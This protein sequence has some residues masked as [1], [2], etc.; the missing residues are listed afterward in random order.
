MHFLAVLSMKNR[1]LIALITIVAAVFGGLALTNLKQELIPSI[2]FPQVAIVSS[3]PGASPEV[4]NNDVSTP[5]ET[6]IQG[7]P[8]LE[9]TSAVSSTN[10]SLI[11]VQFTYGTNLATAEQKLDQAIN[12][13]KSTLPDGVDPQVVSGSIDDLPVIQLAVTGG[14]DQKALGEQITKLA[15]PDIKDV[16]G[17]N[18]AQL[19]GEVGQR[20]TIVPDAAKLAAAGF[21]SQSIKDALQQNGV[22]I[23]GG[24]ITEDDKTLS[25]QSG[26]Q[27][28][29]VDDIASLPL[30]RSASASAG[31]GAGAGASAGAGAGASAGAGPSAAAG[32]AA[33]GA[34]ATPSATATATPTIGEVATV[35]ETDDP[36]TSLSRVDGKP[37]LT[38][39]VTKLPS[40]NTVDVS[41][42]VNALIDDLQTKLGDGV[43]IT[44]VFDQAPF[45]TQ[46]INSLTEEGLLGLL[47][48]V[49]VILVFLLSIRSTLVTAISIPT[50]VLITFI[51]MQATGYTLNI[52]TLGAL[53][54]AIGRVV[55]DSIVVIENIK[56]ELVAGVDRASTIVKA[57][58]EVAGA[59]TASTIVTVAVF[60]PLAF[61]GDVTG[62]LFRPF[63]TTVTIALLSSLLV[64]LTIV[65]VLAYWFLRPPKPRKHEGGAVE[66]ASSHL[67]IDEAIA[68][69]DDELKHPSWLQRGYLPIIHWTLKHSVSTIMIAVLVLV[70]TVFLFPLM[71]TNFLGSSGQNTL[72]ISQTLPPGTSLEAQNSASKPVE[73][74]LLDTKGIDI[75]QL[76]IGSSGSALRDAFTGGGG[77]ITY[78]VTTD[79]DVDQDKLKNTVENELA[80]ITDQGQITVSS[81]QGFG[82]SNDI[83]VNIT[84]T[85]NADLQKATDAVAAQIEK[86]GSIKQTTDNLSASLPYVAVKVNRADAAKA[87]LSEVA[88]G[89][90]VSQAVQ[91]STVGNIAIDNTTLKIYL[92]S[93]N[94]PTTVA[95]LS[96]LEIPTLAGPAR[97]DTLATVAETN[98]PSTVTTERGLRTATV[99]ATPGTDNLG[100]AN[101]DVTKALDSVDLPA[102]ATAKIGGVS[103]SQSD[104]FSQLGLALLA[105][106][107]I[108][109]IVMVATFRSLRQPLL[110]LVSVPFAATG[111]I[112]LQVI[113]GIPLGVASLIGLL[114]LIGIVVTNAIVLIDL[115]N[116]YRRRG[117]SVEDA[118]AHGSSRRL[119]PILMTALATIAALTPMAIGLTGHGGFISQPLAIVV[120]GGL[121]SST[122]LTL[123]VLPTLYNFVEGWKER[124]ASRRTARG[125]GGAGEPGS[126]SGTGPDSSEP[127]SP[128]PTAPEPAGSRA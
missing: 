37:A 21:T 12:R 20:I 61:V 83:E 19:V 116:Q 119:R 53:T 39:A 73:Q 124:R 76:S 80:K 38:I 117:M 78:S 55:D 30:I 63:A 16:K 98:G 44:V 48:A 29:S 40:A 81:S 111:A 95:E 74:V 91:P 13:I 88:V 24:S 41:K 50:S 2:Q 92:Q 70:G 62:E 99:S 56:R 67:S 54:I 77:G 87:G 9:S 60:L 101:A 128:A 59:V 127:D 47:F 34:A 72:T 90:L 123:I 120:I 107:L 58:R 33:S 52:I 42:G 112:A 14:S 25:V 89:S 79:P 82:G 8:D 49:I 97:L 113:S 43:K 11:T 118:V 15:L 1:A 17:V 93:P 126:G 35:Q 23:P 125:E 57:V 7:V 45:I 6:A 69:G 71:K 65:P 64:S 84:A 102:G 10:Q 86:L 51:V 26:S 103:S 4:V 85:S 46:S 5:V 18:D 109:Y 28:G 31:A 66:S 22:L 36:T 122:L 68:T 3:Y 106:I 96:A 108:V 121:V 110:L 105:A 100:T 104:A 75:V 94:P 114:M 115:V 27:L 32:A